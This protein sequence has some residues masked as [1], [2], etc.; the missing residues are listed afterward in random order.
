M[1]ATPPDFP[2]LGREPEGEDP[3]P[4]PEPTYPEVKSLEEEVEELKRRTDEQD[5]SLVRGS[6]QFAGIHR[7]IDDSKDE[8]HRAV[9][10]A[11]AETRSDIRELRGQVGG[12]KQGQ[13]RILEALE[14]TGSAPV[15]TVTPPGPAAPASPTQQD[16]VDVSKSVW[17]MLP[18]AIRIVI[19]SGIAAGTILGGIALALVRGV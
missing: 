3:E 17:S 12:L 1:S 10:T 19:L 2:L 11:R 7:R 5:E 8:L 16:E 14:H 18:R 4:K 15:V 9:T 13:A 6:E